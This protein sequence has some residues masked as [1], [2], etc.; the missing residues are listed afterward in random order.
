MNRST[1]PEWNNAS[2]V[3]VPHIFEALKWLVSLYSFVSYLWCF[4]L[5][6]SNGTKENK[7]YLLVGWRSNEKDK[8]QSLTLYLETK[9]NVQIEVPL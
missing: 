2:R 6:L 9:R 3:K 5:C 1:T 8:E 4:A 7:L